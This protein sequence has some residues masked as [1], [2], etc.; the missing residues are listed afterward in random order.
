MAHHG[1]SRIRIHYG[2]EVLEYELPRGWNLLANP[3]TQ[4][5]P[6]IGRGEMI[7]VLEHP[8]GKP[9]LEEMATE[10]KNAVIIA[11]DVTRPVQGE[12]ALPLMLNCLNHAGIPDNR[13]LLI[14]GGGSHQ[15]PLNLEKAFLQK[16]GNEVIDRVEILYH[17]PDKDFTFLGNTKRGHPVEINKRVVEADLKIAFGGILPHALGG[18]SGGAKSILPAVASRETIIQNHL[19][20]VEAGVGMGLVEGNPIREEI[21]EVAEMV[22]LDFIFNLVLNTEGEPVG[23]V[24]GHF[25]EAHRQGVAFARRIYQAELPRQAQV[26]FTSGHPF[27][28]HFYQSLNGPCAALNGS[29]DGGTIIHLTPAYEGIRSGTKKL[30]SAVNAIGYKDLFARLKEGEREDEPVRSFFY[31]EVNIGMGMTIF[32]AMVDRHVRIV[33]VTRGIASQEL[34]QMGF[35]HAETI[36][37]A[38]SQVYQKVP[39]AEVAAAFNAKVILSPTGKG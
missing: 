30:F 13:I 37:D 39:E 18:Y 23:A 5:F 38:V 6:P 34:Q 36:E 10:R 11:S 25:R 32:R 33:V 26:V 3:G 14:M 16:Y 31:P 19:M 15:P 12:I 35:E 8:I 17:N 9:R 20:V 24:S 21:E 27:D 7:Q 22:G 29:R 28:I 4:Y 2:E 1:D